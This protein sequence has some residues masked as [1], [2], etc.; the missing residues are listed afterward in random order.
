MVLSEIEQFGSHLPQLNLGTGRSKLKVFDG[1]GR[2][3]AQMLYNY[4]GPIPDLVVS[5]LDASAEIDF[6][7]IEKE[8]FIK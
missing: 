1:L 2:F 7:V 6:L 5:S 3:A 4:V 8:P